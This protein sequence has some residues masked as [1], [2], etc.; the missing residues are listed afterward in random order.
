[1]KYTAECVN[2]QGC[3]FDAADFN[4]KKAA[5][6]WASGRGG[7]KLVLYQTDVRGERHRVAE[8][9]KT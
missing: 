5:H 4:S 7:C 8:F 6:S 9:N 3:V 1:M 2:K